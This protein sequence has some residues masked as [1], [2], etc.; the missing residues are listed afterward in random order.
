MRVDIIDHQF[1]EDCEVFFYLSWGGG[2]QLSERYLMM[3]E[4]GGEQRLQAVGRRKSCVF[5]VSPLT[6]ISL[7]T[8]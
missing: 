7:T 2:K 8:S 3:V 6:S 1:P 4:R 5:T